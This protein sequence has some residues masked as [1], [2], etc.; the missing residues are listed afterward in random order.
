MKK[1]I[2]K[3]LLILAAICV[4]IPFAGCKKGEMTVEEYTVKANEFY[5]KVQEYDQ[6]I[7]AIDPK[8]GDACKELLKQLDGL[9]KD[10][11]A[12]AKVTPPKEVPDAK[13]HVEN[14]AKLMSEAVTNFHKA[15]DGEQIDEA[16]LAEANFNYG[17]AVI[18]IKNVGIAMRNAK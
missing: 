6:A 1:S 8:K 15:L 16:A 11:Q 7:N 4:C 10:L 18:E 12:F 14:A 2:K 9:D 5:T 13:E 17:N 3:V